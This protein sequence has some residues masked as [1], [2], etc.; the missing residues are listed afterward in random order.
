M[1]SVVV[2]EALLENGELVSQQPIEAYWFVAER[3][4]VIIIVFTCRFL[5][6]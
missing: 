4:R 3:S 2:Y 1:Y 5:A 6:G